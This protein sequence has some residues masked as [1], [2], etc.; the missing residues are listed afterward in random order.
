MNRYRR[1]LLLP[2]VALLAAAPAAAQ[3]RRP[4]FDG[5][6]LAGWEVA[7][8]GAGGPVEVREGTLFLGAGDPMTGVTW[9]GSFPRIGYEVTLEAKRVAGEDFFSAITF[10]VNDDPCTL[11]IGGWGGSVVGLS[12]IEGSDASENETREFMRFENDRWYRIRLRVTP[13][14]IQAWIG[15]RPVVDFEHIGR[16]LT[17]RME[18]MPNLPFGIATWRTSAAL[19][20]IEL[21][22]LTA[23]ESDP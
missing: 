4:L 6:S 12:S 8:F 11:V 3:E 1:T 18:V 2:L 17:I 22:I 9:K 20:N 13:D 21:R 15:D 16:D 14:S 10:P 19:R 5:R 7:D 23:S